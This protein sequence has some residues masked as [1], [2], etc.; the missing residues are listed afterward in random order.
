MADAPR[1]LPFSCKLYLVLDPAFADAHPLEDLTQRALAAGVRIFQ[2]RVKSPR[3]A[4]FYDA[5]A[6]LCPQIKAA[7]GCFIVNDRCD[8]ALAVGADGVHLGQEDLPLA[9]AREILGPE[10]LI[11]ISTHTVAQAVEACEGGADYIG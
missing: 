3:T 6:G 4:E 10:K 5:A 11:G 2:L 7:G 8:V 9:E 1:R